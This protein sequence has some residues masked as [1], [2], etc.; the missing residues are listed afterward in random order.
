MLVTDYLMPNMTGAQ[1]SAEVKSLRPGLPILLIT[2]YSS[3]SDDRTAALPRLAK[4][5]GQRALGAAVEK[6]V[7]GGR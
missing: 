6:A 3:Q 4:P 2:G 1:L 5:F 7:S